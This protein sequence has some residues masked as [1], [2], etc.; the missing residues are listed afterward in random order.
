MDTCRKGRVVQ[1]QKRVPSKRIKFPNWE[2]RLTSIENR[3]KRPFRHRRT[4]EWMA[5]F[6]VMTLEMQKKLL[7]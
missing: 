3:K 4:S 5:D 2:E 1:C 7:F 6:M